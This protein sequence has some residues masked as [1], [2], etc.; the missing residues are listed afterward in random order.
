[1]SSAAASPT[2]S[3]PD[4]S[5]ASERDFVARFRPEIMAGGFPHDSGSL[6][7]YA[8]IV[9]LLRS[10]M[11]V[12][13]LGAGR[14][15]N[16]DAVEDRFPHNLTRLQGRVAKLVGADVDTAVLTNRHLDEA[17][18]IEPGRPLPFDSARFDLIY[19]DWV[20]EHVEDPQSFSAEIGRIL[21]PG[22]WFCARTPGKWG[23]IALAARLLPGRLHGG[24]LHRVQA[25]RRDEDVFQKY[26]RVNTLR[27]GAAAFPPSRFRNAS[28]MH[29]PTPA[30]HGNRPALFRL[31]E[32]Y[33]RIPIK[34]LGTS[35]HLFVQKIA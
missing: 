1:M 13:D 27:A 12:L 22:G 8:R 10:D 9:S 32:M 25:E 24:V 18:V 31:I 2:R 21:K 16:L 20:L 6:D 4:A 23:Y 26:Y 30:Y 33:Q 7:F 28:Y 11:V 34:A 19:S 17:H 5:V 29:N 3:S 14:G 35:L 15:A